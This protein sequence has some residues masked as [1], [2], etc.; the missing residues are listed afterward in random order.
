MQKH[1]HNIFYYLLLLL[2]QPVITFAAD[3]VTRDIVEISAV[4]GYYGFDNERNIDDAAMAGFGLGLHPSRRWAVLLNYAALNTT[5]NA[6]SVSKKVDM[7]KYHVDGYRFFNTEN[8]LRPYLVAGFG[9]TDLVSEGS[10]INKNMFNAG[11]GISYKMT[12]SWFV[13][14]DARIFA[15][16]DNSYN[17]SALTLTLGYRFAG[18]EK[19]D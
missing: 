18:G 8:R 6:N 7:Q 9:Q 2:L 16:T 10:T 17:D 12:P 1:Q 15:N 19:A 11:F 3:E 14:T 13:R 5:T 4:V